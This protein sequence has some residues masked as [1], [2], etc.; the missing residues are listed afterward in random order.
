ME[1][2][3]RC[4]W[5]HTSLTREWQLADSGQLALTS[6]MRSVADPVDSDLSVSP[7]LVIPAA[8][9]GWRFSRSGGPGGQ[10]VNTT[11][12]RVELSLDLNTLSTVTDFQRARLLR[13]LERRAVDGVVT[14]AASETR[15]QLRNREAARARMAMLLADALTPDPPK[16]RPTTPSKRAKQRRVDAKVQRGRTKRLRGRPKE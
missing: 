3:C 16:R 2:G 4:P 12:S 9:L 10:G 8:E 6:R 1:T 7:R 15:S 11:D 14:I 5:W 13:R